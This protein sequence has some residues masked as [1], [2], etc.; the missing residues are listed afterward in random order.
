MK[1]NL[2]F[3]DI[4]LRYVL[5]FLLGIVFGITQMWVFLGIAVLLFITAV[6]G[7]CPIYDIMG[8]D[9]QRKQHS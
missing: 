3:Y 1:P 9:H 6:T 7:W 2:N 8:I 4:T 5:V